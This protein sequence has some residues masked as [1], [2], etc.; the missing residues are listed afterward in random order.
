M[1]GVGSE[2]D[3]DFGG[4]G[5]EFAWFVEGGFGGGVSCVD[6]VDDVGYEERG[7]LF[8]GGGEADLDEGRWFCH[9]SCCG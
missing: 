1:E 9:W 8:R 5:A 6:E 3:L 7:G 2:P 4:V